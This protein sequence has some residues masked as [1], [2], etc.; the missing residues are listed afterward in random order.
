M[1]IS[2]RVMLPETD[3]HPEATG[4]ARFLSKPLEADLFL[5][6]VNEMLDTPASVRSSS[7][8]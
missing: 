5:K 6:T 8:M 3:P 1:Y 4:L 7:P 2:G